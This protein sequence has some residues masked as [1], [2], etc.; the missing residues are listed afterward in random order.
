MSY[1][2]TISCDLRPAAAN[3]KAREAAEKLRQLLDDAGTSLV[4][5]G[6][7]RDPHQGL[8]DRARR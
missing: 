2:L 1:R 8:E 5:G 7:E 3:K 4:E 6:L